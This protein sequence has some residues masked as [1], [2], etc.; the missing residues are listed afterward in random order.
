MGLYIVLFVVSYIITTISIVVSRD[1]DG[2]L[3]RVADLEG[4]ARILAISLLLFP[5]V[6]FV[7]HAFALQFNN[8]YSNFFKERIK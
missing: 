7:I 5:A 8:D 1:K 4:Q 6:F 3:Y 2:F